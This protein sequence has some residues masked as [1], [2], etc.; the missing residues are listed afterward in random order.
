MG[1]T[2]TTIDFVAIGIIALV[3]AFIVYEISQAASSLQESTGGIFGYVGAAGAGAL[4][5]FLL[6]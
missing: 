2:D 3:V 4:A 1:D 5:L 6:L